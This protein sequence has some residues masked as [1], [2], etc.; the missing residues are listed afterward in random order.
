MKFTNRV[1]LGMFLAGALLLIFSMNSWADEPEKIQSKGYF[2]RY[3]FTTPTEY[4]Y[5]PDG[6]YQESTQKSYSVYVSE[7]PVE[8]QLT[9]QFSQTKTVIHIG[10]DGFW[11]KNWQVNGSGTIIDSYATFTIAPNGKTAYLEVDTNALPIFSSDPVF[12]KYQST[13]AGEL[14]MAFGVIALSFEWTNELWKK[15]E[16]HSNIDYGDYTVRKQG[17]SEYN[18]ADVEG[19]FFD[20]AVVP[21]E[22]G[23]PL[24][25]I[26]RTNT[27][28]ITEYK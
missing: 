23:D 15:E 12:F 6:S 19:S 3:Q 28:T 24:G 13:P 11:F 2:L 5:A 10:T 25:Q 22:F 4:F 21:P 26:G 7:T 9:L 8:D 27:I 1:I 16:T 17:S 18:G 14:P 20:F